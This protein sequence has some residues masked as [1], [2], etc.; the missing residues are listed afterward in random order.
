MG[1]EDASFGF[2]KKELE[3]HSPFY[4]YRAKEGVGSKR[5]GARGWYQNVPPMWL[6]GMLYVYV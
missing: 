5:K 1:E 2:T 3:P 4:W 6:E